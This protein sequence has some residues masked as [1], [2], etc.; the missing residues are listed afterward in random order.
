MT[1]NICIDLSYSLNFDVNLLFMFLFKHYRVYF[2]TLNRN[3]FIHLSAHSE[4]YSIHHYV[5]KF[6]SDLRVATGRCF[7]H[8][9][10]V[11]LTNKTDRHD[12]AETLLK[13]T[14]N[15]IT[16]TNTSITADVLVRV[17]RCNVKLAEC[18]S[19]LDDGTQTNSASHLAG[20]C[21]LHAKDNMQQSIVCNNFLGSVIGV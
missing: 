6:V 20:E 19:R 21:H 1:L 7:S 8:G 16:L 4:V 3:K 11:S 15:T 10:P 13:V 17:Q 14:L 18:N 2:N 9:I 5:I 12:I